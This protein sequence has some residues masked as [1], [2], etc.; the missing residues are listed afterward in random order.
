[1]SLSRLFINIGIIPAAFTASTSSSVSPTYATSLGVSPV[2][3]KAG[4]KI[5][6][7]G[8]FTPTSPQ[9]SKKIPRII[10]ILLRITRRITGA[11]QSARYLHLL[12]FSC[13]FQPI[14]CSEPTYRR[15]FAIHVV[16]ERN[17]LETLSLKERQFVFRQ[18]PRHLP[19]GF[20]WFSTRAMT[21]S[22]PP[23]ATKE[24]M[25]LTMSARRR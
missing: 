4:L 15:I 18:G 24:E 9:R 21:S 22:V 10:L 17:L 11:R 12:G 20:V 6:G 1:M 13:F 16:L 19:F 2:E 8:F 3:D 23:G 25:Q 7:S 5:F 14:S